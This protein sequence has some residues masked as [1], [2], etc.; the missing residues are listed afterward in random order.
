MNQVACPAPDELCHFLDE[1]LEPTRQRE[2]GT[3]VDACLRCQTVLETLT[4]RRASDVLEVSNDF[5]TDGRADTN[6]IRT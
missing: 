3:H 6:L 5:S 4:A 2:V 1:E